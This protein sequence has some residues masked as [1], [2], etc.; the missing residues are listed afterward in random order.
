MTGRSDIGLPMIALTAADLN[1]LEPADGADAGA[2]LAEDYAGELPAGLEDEPDPMTS[3]EDGREPGQS[4]DD[5][6]SD[7][8]VDAKVPAVMEDLPRPARV[9]RGRPRGKRLVPTGTT[10]SATPSVPFP[11]ASAMNPQQ[12]LLVLDTWQRS[13]LPATDFGQMVGIAKQTLNIWKRRFDEFGPEGL[14]DQPKG[15]PKGSRMMEITK[16]T[17]LMIKRANPDYGCE[18]ISAMLLRGPALQASASAVAT[19]LK[20][21]GYVT[22]EQATRPHPDKVR[23]F[24]RA[25]PNQMW[26]TDLFTF[27][28]KRQNRR[29]FLIVYLDDHSRFIVGYGLHASASTEL[30]IEV[31][32]SGVASYG[33][34]EEVLT[35]NGPQFKVW[36]GKSKFTKT[37]EQLGVKQIVARPRHPQT[38]GKTERF[39]GTLWRELLDRSIFLDLGDAKLRI[40]H[41]IDHYNFQRPHQGL[42]NLVPA[43]RYFEAAPEVLKTLKARVAANAL[44]LAQGGVPKPP[45]Y[46]TGQVGGQGFSLHAEGQRV[47]LTSQ[48]G[49]RKEV[50]LRPPTPAAPPVC[51]GATMS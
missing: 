41:F 22:E 30:A 10:P 36:R 49:V 29:V 7:P 15:G 23:H 12:K 9:G 20:E 11:A 45:F 18:R 46:M 26:Q 44:E 39:W 33:A 32:R 31:F 21:N 50:D 2:G 16:R 13:G 19:V 24:E 27:M 1:P 47:I 14:M 4:D 35:D 28:L 5:N 34:P 42:D 40:G 43:D 38:L 8:L 37:M 17:I 25:R 51:T 3:P 48:E 6:A